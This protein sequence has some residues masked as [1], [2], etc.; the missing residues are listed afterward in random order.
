VNT[1]LL[2]GTVDSELPVR[3]DVYIAETLK[4]LSRS[5]LKS[6][7]MTAAVN[8]RSVKLSRIIQSGDQYRI[9]LMALAET[10]LV[11]EQLPLDIIYED[12]AVIVVNKAQGMVTHPAHGNWRG[13]LANALLGRQSQ[14]DQANA[15]QRAGIVH[16]LDKDTSGVIIAARNAPAQDFLAAQF[17]DR[18]TV[19]YYLAIVSGQAP[20][21]QGRVDDWLA[22]D[23][24]ERKR[25]A[26]AAEGSGKRA[27]SDYQVLA[28][29][30][31][32]SLL[33]L[34]PRTGRT[35]QLRVHCLKLGCP[36]LGDPIYGRPGRLLPGASLML[37]AAQLSIRLPAEELLRRFEAPLPEHF[38]RALARLKLPV[39]EFPLGMPGQ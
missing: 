14:G 6:R 5:Q 22:R 39:P 4:L 18:S 10:S 11:A 34:R 28:S 12:S 31:G 36:I 2:S 9:E 24:R 20:A 3:L 17:R 26:P 19:K 25:F 23:P 1:E 27:V 29:A 30:A 37:H 21:V 38:L 33:L 8:G 13:T 32:C 35:H 7:C 15:P 16:R